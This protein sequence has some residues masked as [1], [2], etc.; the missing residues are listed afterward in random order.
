MNEKVYI[1]KGA[2]WRR[3]VAWTL[4]VLC[5][6]GLGGLFLYAA[7]SKIQ[8]PAAFAHAVAAYDVLPGEAVGLV[9]LV[10][11]MLELVA[12]VALLVTAWPREVALVLLGL[13]GVFFV[14]LI[15]AQ[16]R[17]LDISC[18]C[19]GDSGDG[20]DSI[21]E[22]LIRDVVLL[23][24]LVWLVCR[25][26][27]WL[28]GSHGCVTRARRFRRDHVV[29]G[30]LL[31][32]ALALPGRA[33]DVAPATNNA[34]LAASA[35]STNF[36][37]ALAAAQTNHRPLV[38]VIGSRKCLHCRRLETA[39]SGPVFRNWTRGMELQLARTHVEDTNR[40]PAQAQMFAFV[41]DMKPKEGLEYPYVGVYWPRA[42]GDAVQTVFSGRRG[43]MPGERHAALVGEF[44]SALD[45][46]LGDYLTTRPA[47]PTID[48]L[49][50][51]STKTFTV[52]TDGKGKVTLSPESGLLRDDGTT[53]RLTIKPARGSVFAGIE[54]PDGT[55]LPVRK[56]AKQMFGTYLYEIR[57]RMRPGTYTVLFRPKAY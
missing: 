30:A 32:V 45:A 1:P 15:Q 54:L 37:V 20:K 17:G 25:P 22:A 26:N 31:A 40:C 7:L 18:G 47:R 50:E 11:P 55:T 44:T 57:Y 42:T 23:A 33:E 35:W 10:L 52:K 2:L 4:D 6:V 41:M 9:A 46:V 49:L 13:M 39:L 51:D 12:G 5:R 43:L 24:P 34:A 36:P 56:C 48:R 27:G 21:M 16:V 53:L 14:G 8:D 28:L 29:A 38:V 19:F 3:R